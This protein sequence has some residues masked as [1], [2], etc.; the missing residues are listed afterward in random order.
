MT[1]KYWSGNIEKHKRGD[2]N[3]RGE[4]NW[5]GMEKINMSCTRRF[6]SPYRRLHE[7]PTK[8]KDFFFSQ[9]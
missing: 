3:P 1:T 6:M 4:Q 7:A 5:Q 8:L 9:L 2:D